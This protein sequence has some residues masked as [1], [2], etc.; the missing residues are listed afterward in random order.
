M[1]T[2]IIGHMDNPLS[3]I[4]CD[5]G[6]S[7]GSANAYNASGSSAGSANAS[8]ASVPVSQS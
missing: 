5:C 6:S 3:A 4:C 7:A 1:C 2:P 8:N